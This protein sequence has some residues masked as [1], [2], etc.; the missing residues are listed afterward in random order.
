M[1]SGPFEI[2]VDRESAIQQQLTVSDVIPINHDH[3]NLVR[4]AEDSA[5]YAVIAQKLREVTGDVTLDSPQTA[6]T[7]TI[8]N[9][10]RS[11]FEPWKLLTSFSRSFPWKQKSEAAIIP[12]PGILQFL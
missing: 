3:S 6:P 11:A 10:E 7:T 1:R 4:F 2:L 5:D 8:G 9:N 12:N